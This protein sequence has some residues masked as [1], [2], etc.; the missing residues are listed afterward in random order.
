MYVYMCIYTYRHICTLIHLLYYNV[1]KTKYTKKDL[2][3]SY[4]NYIQIYLRLIP[5]R[6]ILLS[7]ITNNS[8]QKRVLVSFQFVK[9]KVIIIPN[10]F[11]PFFNSRC[12]L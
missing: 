6:K 10:V 9:E 8:K 7:M 1:G 2:I 12:S 4:I 3:T 5:S 11:V